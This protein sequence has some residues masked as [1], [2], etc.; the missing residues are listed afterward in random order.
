MVAGR[1]TG[2]EGCN[3]PGHGINRHDTRAVVLPIVGMGRLVR[4]GGKQASALQA[5]L[6]RQVDGRTFRLQA[7][8]AVA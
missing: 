4:I 8:E 2:N 5:A 6:E 3:V 1:Q 7:T